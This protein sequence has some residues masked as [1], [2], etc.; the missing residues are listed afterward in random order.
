[1]TKAEWIA[2]LADETGLTRKTVGAVLD[3]QG[4]QAFG[5][6]QCGE[7]VTLP[8]LGRLVVKGRKG[9]TMMSFGK[10]IRTEDRNVVKFRPV[11]ALKESV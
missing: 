10:K 7:E 3:A 11:R 8:G 6:L 4:K 1:M 9:R 2:R 5:V